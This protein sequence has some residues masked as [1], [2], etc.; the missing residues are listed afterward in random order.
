MSLAVSAQTVN[1]LT[2]ELGNFNLDSL[3]TLYSAEPTMYRASLEVLEQNVQKQLDA[4][5]LVKKEIKAEQNHAKEL[6]NSLKAASKMT[7]AMKKLYSQEEAELKAMQKTVDK[8]QKSFAKQKDLNQDTRD[9][10]NLFLENEQKE[11]SYSLRE[12]ADRQRAITDLETYVQTTQGQLQNF[13]QEITQKTA[14]LVQI[15]TELKTRMTTVK[16]E[17]KA[18]KGLQ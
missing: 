1:P 14:S 11:L 7:A 5:A 18:A 9:S 10:Y 13:Q 3:R 4:V 12:V 15:E 6:A 16:A 17:K 8:Q 2:I